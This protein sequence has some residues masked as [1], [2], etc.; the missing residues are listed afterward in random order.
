MAIHPTALVDR[1]A[2][3]DADVE[4]GPF[5]VIE[6]PVR[7]G[8]R[9]RV[10]AH[11][12]IT[13]HTRLGADNLVHAGAVIGDLPQDRSFTG[14]ESYVV[15]GDRNVFRESVTVH[16]GTQ[17]GSSTAIGNDN[18]L[19]VNAHVGHN[20]R[21]G[22]HVVLVNGALLAGYVQVGDRALVSGN[23]AVHQHVRLGTLALVRGVSR[24]TRDVPPFCVMDETGVIRG[25]NAVGLRRAG[26][27]AP[28]MRALRRAF[29]TLFRTRR[30]LREAMAEL[31]RSELTGD[32]RHLLEFI[33]AST[34]GV[35]FGPRV[36]ARAGE[37]SDD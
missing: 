11:A 17:P 13:G 26:F 1:R 31:E 27:D 25:L 37:A 29:T 16:R 34:R 10:A 6:G 36:D 23:A 33:R 14:A 20:C 21:I 15:I 4:V 7:L 8:A 28:R 3:L 18:Y 19:M 35:C 2:E 22:D 30:N 12:V 32:V 24:A 5:A 9:T